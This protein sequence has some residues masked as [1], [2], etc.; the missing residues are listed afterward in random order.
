M[1]NYKYGKSKKKS[2]EKWSRDEKVI[3]QWLSDWK[4]WRAQA[5]KSSMEK[6]PIVNQTKQVQ[7]LIQFCT[8][9]DYWWEK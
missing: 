5:Q 4:K 9:S 8:E 6:C 2:N 3:N 1:T 7:Q